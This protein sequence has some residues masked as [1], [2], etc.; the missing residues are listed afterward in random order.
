MALVKC[1]ECGR[2]GVSSSA[3]SCPNCGFNLREHFLNKNEEMNSELISELSKKYGCN[4]S[5]EE[6]KRIEYYEKSQQREIKQINNSDMAEEEKRRRIKKETENYASLIN[7]I[8][9]KC[10]KRNQEEYD[11][12]HDIVRCPRCGSTNVDIGKRGFSVVTG[13]VGSNKTVN[14]CGKCGYKWKPRNW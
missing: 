2:E 4:L 5:P 9:V 1:P 8:V 13:F 14:R 12:E 7:S 11:K 3:E 6:E 10:K